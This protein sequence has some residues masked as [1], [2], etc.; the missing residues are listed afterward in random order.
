MR[1]ASAGDRGI[2]DE[3][4]TNSEALAAAAEEAYTRLIGREAP[5]DLTEES[6]TLPDGPTEVLRTVRAR[7]VQGFFA[8]AVLASYEYR[9]ALTG[10]G[11]REL[12][13]ASH[14]IP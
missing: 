5:E 13:N 7:R 10:L 4:A 2:W 6:L 8:A 9:C 1:G 14:I 3:F 11:V 12:L